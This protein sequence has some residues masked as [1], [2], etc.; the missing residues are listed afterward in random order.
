MWKKGALAPITPKSEMK[1]PHF[2]YYFLIV[3]A[4]VFDKADETTHVRSDAHTIFIMYSTNS[5]CYGKGKGKP[6]MERWRIEK[7]IE[8]PLSNTAAVLCSQAHPHISNHQSVQKFQSR[9]VC[10]FSTRQCMSRSL[11]DL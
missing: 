11:M 3:A 2:D 10:R 4:W 7:G 1:G 8:P 6:L 5:F 9:I